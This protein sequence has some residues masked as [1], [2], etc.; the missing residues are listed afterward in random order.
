MKPRLPPLRQN[1]CLRSSSV[2]LGS[3]IFTVPTTPLVSSTAL[4]N[5]ASS[6]V[7]LLDI[8]SM[9]ISP[10]RVCWIEQ[11]TAPH[12]LRSIPVRIP[13]RILANVPL[14][15]TRLVLHRR[16]FSLSFQA[17]LLPSQSSSKSRKAASLTFFSFFPFSF[18]S[19]LMSLA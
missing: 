11:T 4:L 9:R 18:S 2:T 12:F 14:R 10:V 7:A 8:Y 6:L 17:F 16:E 1:S 15:S 19:F 5:E 3:K 13:L